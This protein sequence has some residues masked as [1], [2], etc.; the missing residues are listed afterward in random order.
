MPSLLHIRNNKSI[1]IA[2]LESKVQPLEIPLTKG[3]EAFWLD[4][5]TVAHV[6]KHEESKNLELY[7]L[8]VKYETQDAS[9]LTLLDHPIL[10]GSFPT[11]TA[12][13]FRYISGAGQLIF[14]DN[15]FPDGNLKTVKEQDDN[16]EN[17]GTTALV[18]DSTY[19]RYV[20]P[21]TE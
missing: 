9:T 17:R 2:A 6:V 8:S 10:V 5:R 7:A 11:S 1:F 13:N 16:W 12:T 21:V 4:S 3:G 18:Y 15:V 14:S 20:R 19:E